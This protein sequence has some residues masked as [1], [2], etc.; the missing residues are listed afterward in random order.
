MTVPISFRFAKFSLFGWLLVCPAAGLT[1]ACSDDDDEGSRLLPSKRPEAS[2]QDAGK[3]T[4]GFFLI[5]YEAIKRYSG[6]AD[7]FGGDLGGIE[8]ADSLCQ[9][10]A[11]YSTPSAKDKTWRAFLSTTKEDAIDRIGDGPWYDRVGRLVANNRDE[12]L[13]DRPRNADPEIIDDLPNEYGIPNQFPN[14]DTQAVDNHQTLTGSGSD[15]RLYEQAS[16]GSGG[17]SPTQCPDGWTK[18]KATCWDWT[19]KEPEGCPRVGHSWPSNFSG[20]NWISVWNEGGCAPGTNLIQ[21]G[22]LT[23]EATVGSGGGYGGFYC[24][25]LAD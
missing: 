12:L 8:G 6:S 10:T 13:N 16:G 23:G 19:S 7:G 21:T 1:S 18:E 3:D 9:Q 24:F 20:R 25:A 14:S 17:G 2:E 4:F 11:E 5:S 22:G 15:G